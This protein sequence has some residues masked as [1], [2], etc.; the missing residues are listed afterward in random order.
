MRCLLRVFI[1]F[2]NLPGLILGFCFAASAIGQTIRWQDLPLPLQRELKL[3]QLEEANFEKYLASINQAT[4]ARERDGEFDH[5]IFFA[6]DRK[7]VV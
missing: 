5:L 6:L 4:E 3:K 1:I 7:S 2:T